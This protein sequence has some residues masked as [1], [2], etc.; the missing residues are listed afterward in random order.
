MSDE[1]LMEKTAAG[2]RNAAAEIYKRYSARIYRYFFRMFNAN[3]ASAEDFT[4]ELFLKVISSANQFKQGHKVSTWLYSIAGNMCKNEWRNHNN[5]K[6]ILQQIET[7]TISQPDAGQR[8]DLNT[9]QN[10][11]NQLLE[12]LNPDDK[13]LIVLRFQQE[14]SIK[15]IASILDIPE[16]TV[17]SR[18]FYLLKKMNAHLKEFS[19]FFQN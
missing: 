4:H 10:N 12:N 15:E 6:A 14:L 17:K 11:L 2:E 3:Q 13:D 7:E 8:K 1:L 18:I 5:R 19:E 9:I 16:G